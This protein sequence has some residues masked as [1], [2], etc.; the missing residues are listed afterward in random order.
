LQLSLP[1]FVIEQSLKVSRGKCKKI[2]YFTHKLEMTTHTQSLD[3][4]MN[5]KAVSLPHFR[6]TIT[7]T[8]TN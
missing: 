3:I 4:P 6:K 1:I 2:P 5:Q 8:T 7:T